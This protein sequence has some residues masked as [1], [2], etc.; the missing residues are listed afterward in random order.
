MVDTGATNEVSAAA[1][2]A[3][4]RETVDTI[5][6]LTTLHP[7][8]PG[9]TLVTVCLNA[10]TEPGELKLATELLRTVWMTLIPAL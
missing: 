5:V 4:S 7:T 9:M 6:T 1:V 10:A 2:E 8:T 3:D